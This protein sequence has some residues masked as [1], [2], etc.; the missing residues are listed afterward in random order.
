P[1]SANLLASGEHLTPLPDAISKNVRDAVTAAMRSNKA[2][3]PQTID[4]FLSILDGNEGDDDDEVT[5]IGVEQDKQAV[6][7]E[8][9]NK[10]DDIPPT[11]INEAKTST[12]SSKIIVAVA[13]VLVLAVA[14]ILGVALLH[15]AD[16]KRPKTEQKVTEVTNKSM[17]YEGVIY[18]YTGP[19][20]ETGNAE[21]EGTGVYSDGTYTGEYVDGCREG[22]G[23]FVTSDGSNTFTG[24]FE[25]DMYSEG[26]LTMD[27]GSYFEGTFEDNEFDTGSW[28]TS[29]G[30][31]D[32]KMVN[33][34]YK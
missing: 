13:I 29:S 21:G 17:E 14:I 1:L 24:T 27:D 32:G 23:T 30:I 5:V 19:V 18:Q 11:Q 31:F 7:P 2:N 6:K 25:N 28:Y 9:S 10:I 20:N 16:I 3:R 22:K 4:D 33:G 8:A 34:Q 12:L 26:T 15:K